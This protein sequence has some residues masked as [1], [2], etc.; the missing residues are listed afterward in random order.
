MFLIF[1]KS[2]QGLIGIIDL[3]MH[4]LRWMSQ[5]SLT[6]TQFTFKLGSLYWL[7]STE[8]NHIIE[9]FITTTSR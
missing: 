7:T 9:K 3:Y 1:F 4:L 2:Y 5:T 6:F 8:F